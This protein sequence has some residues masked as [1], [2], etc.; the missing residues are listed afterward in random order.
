[1]TAVIARMHRAYDERLGLSEIR[2]RF[3][4]YD[5][6]YGGRSQIRVAYDLKAGAYRV[7]ASDADTYDPITPGWQVTSRSIWHTSVTITRPGRL[8]IG[9]IPTRVYEAI[10]GDLA[11]READETIERSEARLD[12]L[13]A[14]ME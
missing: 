5:E 14:G 7:W 4:A 1:M 12:A 3:I 10:L 2:E 8:E 9:S 6:K 13:L 11:D